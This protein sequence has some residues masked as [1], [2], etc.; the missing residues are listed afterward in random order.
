MLCMSKETSFLSTCAVV[1]ELLD[2]S[3]AS[4]IDPL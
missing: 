3:A 2:A 1:E 4:V